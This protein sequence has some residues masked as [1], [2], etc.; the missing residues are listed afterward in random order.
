LTRGKAINPEILA[1]FVQALDIPASAK[2]RLMKL[3]PGAYTGNAA[4]MA[5]SLDRNDL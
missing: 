4:E 2:Q 3:T 5:H 1:E